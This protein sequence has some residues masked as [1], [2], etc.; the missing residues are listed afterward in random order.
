M[1]LFEIY[2]ADGFS[3]TV[4]LELILSWEEKIIQ[5]LNLII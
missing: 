4:K 5:F 1:G 3:D 2:I